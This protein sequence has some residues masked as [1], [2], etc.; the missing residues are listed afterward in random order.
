MGLLLAAGLDALLNDAPQIM[1]RQ[2]D[3]K[4][5]GVTRLTFALIR[6][7]IPAWTAAAFC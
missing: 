1:A 3:L 4:N 2:A 7:T 5:R 6:P